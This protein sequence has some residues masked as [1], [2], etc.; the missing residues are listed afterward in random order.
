[1]VRMRASVNNEESLS[2]GGNRVSYYNAIKE[3]RS[4]SSFKAKESK[5]DK[6]DSK[7]D[8]S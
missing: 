5:I 8:F 3:S 6:K 2:P 1:M 7:S 4:R